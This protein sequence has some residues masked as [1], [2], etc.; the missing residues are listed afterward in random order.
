M[1]GKTGFTTSTMRVDLW[2]N[3]YSQKP[4]ALICR[5][6]L[7][8][9]ADATAS[10]VA[11]QFNFTDDLVGKSELKSHSWL[12]FDKMDPITERDLCHSKHI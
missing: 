11:L 2:A 12:F 10:T 1:L 4:K 6:L 5:Y 7:S 8:C 3:S 9:I